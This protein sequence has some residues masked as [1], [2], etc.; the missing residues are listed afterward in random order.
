MLTNKKFLIFLN[1]SNFDFL[2]RIEELKKSIHIIFSKN[3]DLSKEEPFLTR[4][5]DYISFYYVKHEE[6]E[7]N[8]A[9]KFESNFLTQF[10]TIVLIASLRKFWN[11]FL[12]NKFEYLLEQKPNEALII[13]ELDFPIYQSKTNKK[14]LLLFQK[15][16]INPSF[17]E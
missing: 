10:R 3:L 13:F 17:R 14:K 12:G 2:K 15:Q 5:K 16:G 7:K 11:V 9:S 8:N 4:M 1:F 6:D